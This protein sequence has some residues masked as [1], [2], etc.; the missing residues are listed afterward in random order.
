MEWFASQ[1]MI[2][3]NAAPN[4]RPFSIVMENGFFMRRLPLFSNRNAPP[5][6]GV[7]GHDV[8]HHGGGVPVALS[9]SGVGDLNP[10]LIARIIYEK[11]ECQAQ[12]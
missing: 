12:K 1:D 4:P 6:G 11:K 5:L 10:G 8:K 3:A 9:F 2:A 7:A